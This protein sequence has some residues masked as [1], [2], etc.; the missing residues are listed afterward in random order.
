MESPAIDN[1]ELRKFNEETRKKSK[2]TMSPQLS[3]SRY[4]K[5][6]SRYFSRIFSKFTG[7]MHLAKRFINKLKQI[8]PFHSKLT[9]EANHMI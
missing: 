9:S 2:A 1:L 5:R 7:K 4:A 6:K 8:R 3:P